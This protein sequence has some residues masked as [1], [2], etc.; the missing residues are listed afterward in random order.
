MGRWPLLLAIA[1]MLPGGRLQAQPAGGEDRAACRQAIEAAEPASGLPPGL[2][3]AIA[4][5]ESGRRDSSSGRTEPWPW[6]YNAAG[7]GRAAPSKQAAI[8]EVSALLARGLRSVDIGCMQVNL[9]HHPGAFASLDE[10]FDPRANLRYAIRFLKELR[11]RHGDWGQA[12]AHYHSGEPERGRAYA[13]RVATIG[14]G[15]AGMTRAAPPAPAPPAPDRVERVPGLT[16]AEQRMLERYARGQDE[17]TALRALAATDP[18]AALRALSD[19][20]LY[21][22]LMT[23]QREAITGLARLRVEMQEMRLQARSRLARPSAGGRT[24][25]PE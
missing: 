13:R 9:L 23:E 2:L 20:R 3:R 25:L 7:E 12:I 8:A 21:R 16:A 17:W 24:A 22:N 4:L 18:A 19:P 15:G 14:A 5:V 10:A 6:S 11:E 1:L